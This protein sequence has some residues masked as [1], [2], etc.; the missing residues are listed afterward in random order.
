MFRYLF[1]HYF[2]AILNSIYFRP[3]L[4]NKSQRDSFK[5]R[6]TKISK[7]ISSSKTQNHS[8]D[9]HGGFQK[10]ISGK[11]QKM[12]QPK[13]VNGFYKKPS[14]L[15]NFSLNI[16]RPEEQKAHYNSFAHEPEQ[17]SSFKVDLDH[18]VSTREDNTQIF[19]TLNPSRN[20]GKL[21]KVATKKVER[22]S[23]A[24][25]SQSSTHPLF[26]P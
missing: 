3:I 1:L 18:P 25:S 6:D 8:L 4:E 19:E 5:E 24:K 15:A 23:L 10:K 14:L 26:I 16:T 21:E 7:I 12:R 9:G 2:Q 13:Q 17:R 22:S 20:I 11:P